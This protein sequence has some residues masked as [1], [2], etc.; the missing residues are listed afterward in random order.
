MLRDY[1]VKPVL[2]GVDPNTSTPSAITL[3][4]LYDV[5]A[6]PFQGKTNTEI[7]TIK[8]TLTSQQGWKFWLTQ[9]GEKSMGA[10]LVLQGQLY[11]TSFLPQV[12]SFQQCTIQSIGAM[13]QYMIDMHYGS[14]FKRVL[15]VSG[16][17]TDQ[18]ERYSEVQN[19]VADD[20]VIHGGD[21]GRIRVIGGAPGSEVVLTSSGNGEPARCGAA[22]ECAQ[23]AET[24]NMD[25][26]PKK[27]YIFEGEAR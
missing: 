18:F 24:V 26:L 6:D 4:D 14:S 27:I 25:M 19:K 1:D 20:L 23:G 5:T 3:D 9:S 10:G 21:D 16:N 15:D 13:R 12:Q 8:Q 7:L 11:F 17:E 22:G 2:F